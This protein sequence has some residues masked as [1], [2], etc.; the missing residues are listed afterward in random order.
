MARETK[1][2]KDSARPM[3]KAEILELA[4]KELS[5][6]EFGRIKRLK[7]ILGSASLKTVVLVELADGAEAVMLVQRPHA[8][9]Q[10]ESNLA[11]A[12][13]FLGELSRRGVD[14]PSGMFDSLMGALERQ[15]EEETRM[16]AEAEKIRAAK[17]YYEGLNA[18][19]GARLGR[20]RFRVPGLVEGFAVRDGILFVEKAEGKS[21]DKLGAEA[22]GESGRWIVESALRLLFRE[23]WFDADRHLGN[24][25][26]DAENGLIYPLDF[27]QAAVFSRGA[28]WKTDDRYRLAQFIRALDA[29][30]ADG[31]LRHGLGMAEGPAPRDL[32][33]L[34]AQIRRALGGESS[35]EDRIVRLMNAFADAGAPLADRFS[36]GAFK[37][38][39]TLYGEGYVPPETFRAILSG[40]IERSLKR[41]WLRV[42]LD[43]WSKGE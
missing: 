3:S 7:R 42:V 41:K 39:L 9:A 10:I 21:F 29:G 37:G 6:R 35:L 33:A 34:R 24:H 32:P 8:R 27:G 26:V 16:T 12:R 4:R 15:L 20:W 31:T 14:I 1:S 18:S 36:F 38:L 23:G 43:R 5:P 19:L 40:E 25:L 2:L 28:F 11:L 22:R 30:D 13:E 17:A